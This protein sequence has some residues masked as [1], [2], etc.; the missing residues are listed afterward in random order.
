ML[1]NLAA[2]WAS[3]CKTA[4]EK[5]VELV[6]KFGVAHSVLEAIVA[7]EVN[8]EAIVAC[9]VNFVGLLE[10][11]VN[12]SNGRHDSMHQRLGPDGRRGATLG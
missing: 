12:L 9:M 3:S 1:S 10:D 8:F 5:S 6:G 7:C 4:V 11:S 2:S